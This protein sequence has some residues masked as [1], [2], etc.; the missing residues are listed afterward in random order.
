MIGR[1]I[2]PT[3][4]KGDGQRTDRGKQYESRHISA[5][6]I[7]PTFNVNPQTENA[8]GKRAKD[9]EQTGSFPPEAAVRN[10]TARAQGGYN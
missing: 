1:R 9:R 2:N 6:Q 8:A 3:R 10:T 4:H 7:A 5:E